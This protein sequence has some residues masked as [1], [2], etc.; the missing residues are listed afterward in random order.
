MK[1][2]TVPAQVTTIEDTIVGNLTPTQVVLFLIPLFLSLAI[3]IV[4]PE[5]KHI[6]EPKALTILMVFSLFFVLAIRIQGKLILSW[7]VIFSR[8]LFRPHLYLFSK[9]D[10][11][12]KEVTS[13]RKV[14]KLPSKS[15]VGRKM[16]ASTKP[17]ETNISPLFA[18]NSNAF[19]FSL[20]N[21]GMV[22][23]KRYD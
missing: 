16:N 11:Y 7:L 13:E 18:G 19:T 5:P 23:L 9:S 14:W 12:L 4:V 10:I 20:N 3:Y 2:A 17:K 1:T 21:N 22:Q 6:T 8:Y 15:P